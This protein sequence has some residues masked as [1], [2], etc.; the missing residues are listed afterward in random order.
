[1]SS[2]IMLSITA[3]QQSPSG[4]TNRVEMVTEGRL[5][6]ENDTLCLEYQENESTGF[7]DATTTVMVTGSVVSVVRR[8]AH[9]SHMVF[10]QGKKSYNIYHTPVGPMEMAVTPLTMDLN[11]ADDS[12]ELHLEYE[13]ELGG[14]Y[15]GE[16]MLSIS[17][18]QKRPN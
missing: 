11:L 6:H 12:G 2:N 14:N 17:Y 3:E 10:S 8:G 7:G 1:M 13:L 15:I 18:R 5:F 4:D 16:N 9:T